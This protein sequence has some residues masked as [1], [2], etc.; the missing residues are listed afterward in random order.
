MVMGQGSLHCYLVTGSIADKDSISC[1]ARGYREKRSIWS[2][3]PYLKCNCYA[4][5][6]VC[7]TMEYDREADFQQLEHIHRFGHKA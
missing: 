6:S 7:K 5:I 1:S 4:I 3:I 2:Y